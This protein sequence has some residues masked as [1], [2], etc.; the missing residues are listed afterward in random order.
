MGLGLLPLAHA[1]IPSHG[2]KPCL[3]MDHWQ[4]PVEVGPPSVP[5]L[6]FTF[7]HALQ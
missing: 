1:L 6:Y 4:G 5:P 2:S 3:P 7:R